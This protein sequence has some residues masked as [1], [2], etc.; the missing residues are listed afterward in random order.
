MNKITKILV[1]EDEPGF[2]RLINQRFR[3]EIRQGVYAF[4]FA[5]NGI[6]AL[7]MLDN[8]LD[9]DIVLT[10]INMPGMDGLTMLASLREKRPDLVTM[11]ISAYNDMPNIRAAMNLGAFDFVTKPINFADLQIT[12]QKTV[13][14]VE[15]IR[16]ASKAQ[17]LKMMNDQL[18]D[19]DRMKSQFLTN[20]TH[21]FRTP[22]TIIDGMAGQIEKKPEKWLTRGVQM[23]KRNS[24][25]LL[26]LVDQIMDLAK[27]EEGNMKVNMV[28]GNIM[29]VI[30]QELLRC[31]E[32]AERKQIR[33]ELIDKVIDQ[34]MDLDPDKLQKIVYNLL[35]NAVKFT[36]AGGEVQLI[37]ERAPT[38]AE[39]KTLLIIVKDNGIGISSE[40]LPFIFNRF[41]QVDGSSTREGEGTGIGLA[42]VKEML[43][44][45]D[46]TVTVNST[47]GEG[48]VFQVVLPIRRSVAAYN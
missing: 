11:I 34:T 36:P 23:I 39:E 47:V 29:D 13:K 5:G 21:E 15:T 10:D 40:H 27:L 17:E 8:D 43:D 35:S 38:T 19:M 46:G 14:V 6:E 18:R 4:A 41:F 20:V 16:Q 2:E 25:K 44:L 24:A 30:R 22:L 28:Q 31:E 42:L 45:M 33:I 32:L 48:S 7:K 3:K 12:L 37:V 26:Y 1:V 9:F